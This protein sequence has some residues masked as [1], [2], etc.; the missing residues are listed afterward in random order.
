MLS[1]KTTDSMSVGEPNSWK[2]SQ[3][4][5]NETHA[6]SN[7]WLCSSG[8]CRVRLLLNMENQLN[9][10]S[11]YPLK[12]IGLKDCTSWIKEHW[13]LKRLKHLDPSERRHAVLV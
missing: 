13:P 8:G 3:V 10:F 6:Y 4:R 7:W 5:P 11:I 9:F 2:R 12:S 1:E